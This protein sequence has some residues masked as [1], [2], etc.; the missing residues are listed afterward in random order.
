VT[1][2]RAERVILVTGALAA[3]AT[4]ASAP[5]LFASLAVG[6]LVL[7]ALYALVR[8]A[9]VLRAARWVRAR[10]RPAAVVTVA[11]LGLFA[12]AAF[13]GDQVRHPSVDE[14]A[15]TALW[16]DANADLNHVAAEN[17][18]WQ[19]A[20]VGERPAEVAKVR[21]AVTGFARTVDVLMRVRPPEAGRSTYSSV[22]AVYQDM[23]DSLLALPDAL[24]ASDSNAV[25]A[26][27]QRVSMLANEAAS[28]A[29]LTAPMTH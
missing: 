25:G 5:D 17:L 22:A 26:I 29:Q 2:R 10:G 15:E 7:L 14:A 24:A 8:P 6:T 1:R 16:N 27:W 3:L 13:A 11:A 21:D 23:A 4:I 12:L 9:L 19:Y 18:R 28:F 20:D